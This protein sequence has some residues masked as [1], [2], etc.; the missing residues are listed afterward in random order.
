MKGQQY[1]SQLFLVFELIRGT[2][3][4]SAGDAEIGQHRSEYQDTVSTSNT[5]SRIITLDTKDEIRYYEAGCS[6][7]ICKSLAAAV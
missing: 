2:R 7:W 6:S 3:S 5:K 4:S 1:M